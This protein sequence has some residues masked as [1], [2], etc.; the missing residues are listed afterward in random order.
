[1]IKVI[2]IYEVFADHLYEDPP[3]EGHTC[4]YLTDMFGDH[5]TLCHCSPEETDRCAME[6]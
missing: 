4:P 1:M 2:S 6:I 3:D 5:Q